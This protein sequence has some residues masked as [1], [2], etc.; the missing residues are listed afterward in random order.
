MVTTKRARSAFEWLEQA[1][2]DI[3]PGE[4]VSATGVPWAVYLRLAELRDDYHPRVRITFDRG[5][6][7]LMSPKFRHEK[8]TL[9]LGLIVHAL[10]KSLGFKLAS[11]R[12]TRLEEE[13]AEQALEP[14]DCFYIANAPA[15]LT[16]EDIDLAIHPPP[17]LAIEVDVSRSSVPK[18]PIY[19]TM[20]VP[21]LWRHD[22]GNVVIRVLSQDGTYVTNSTSRSFP[23]V[24]AEDLKRLLEETKVLDDIDAAE[25]FLTWAKTLVPPAANP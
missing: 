18:E 5:R 20:G 6:I 15:I 19:S 3:P 9:R 13:Q 23:N 16:V 21:E 17:D 8:P 10:A 11:A 22:K 1:L 24:T 12:S 7:E 2:I 25:H 14:D 4:R